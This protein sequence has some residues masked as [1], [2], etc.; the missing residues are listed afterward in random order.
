M[1]PPVKIGWWYERLADAMIAHPEKTLT[2][3]AKS[4]NC[5]LTW[6]SIIKNSDVFKEYWARRSAEASKDML[7]A[8][9]AKGMAA[10]ELAIDA[11]NARLELEASAM[12]VP[13]LLEVVDISMKR[14]GYDSAKGARAP[15]TVTN[16][17]IGMVS[18]AEL[19]E[20][21]AR[22]RQ[23]KIDVVDAVAEEHR[24]EGK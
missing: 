1:A 15:Q 14:F 24:L 6:I 21:R 8:I 13:Q 5:T 12:P 20:A 17:N 2:E 10:A 18:A 22:M 9:R 19:A 3:I 11:L 16:F 4:F 23:A 7:G